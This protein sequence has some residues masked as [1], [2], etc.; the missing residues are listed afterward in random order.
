MPL[1]AK[2][3]GLELPEI[4]PELAGLNVLVDIPM[5]TV[6]ENSSIAIW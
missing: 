2:A 3:N 5:C 6:H 4:P 1:L